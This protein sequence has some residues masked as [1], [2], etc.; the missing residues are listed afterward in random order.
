MSKR[1]VF[2]ILVGLAVLIAALLTNFG[3]NLPVFPP[4]NPVFTEVVPASRPP[5]LDW[6]QLERFAGQSMED[7]L[8]TLTAENEAAAEAE[9][10]KTPSEGAAPLPKESLLGAL[11]DAPLPFP[12]DAPPI[13][14]ARLREFVTTAQQGPVDDPTPLEKWEFNLALAALDVSASQLPETIRMDTAPAPESDTFPVRLVKR[15]LD[16]SGPFAVANFDDDPDLEIVSGGGT[17]VSKIADDSVVAASNAPPTTVAGRGL[18]PADFDGDGNVDLFVVRGAGLPNSLLRNDGA[19]QFEDVTIELGLLSFDDTTTAAWLDYDG[20][21]SLDLLVG[22]A[23]HPLELYHQSSGGVFQPIAWDL[24]LWVPRGVRGIEVADFSGN[25][26]PDF[27]LSI[28]GLGDRLCLSRPAESWENWRFP[29]RASEAGVAGGRDEASVAAAWD[30][31]ND[32]HADL[33]VGGSQEPGDAVRLYRNGGDETFVEVGADT[34]LAAVETASA[35]AVFDL[36][37]DGFEDLLIGT[38]QLAMNRLFWNRG[39]LGF[40][41]V[42]VVARASYLDRPLEFLA[43]DLDGDGASDLLSRNEQGRIRR[44]EAT[45]GGE[46]WL[47]IHLSGHAPGTRLRLTVRD[48]DW[49]LHSIARTVRLEDRITIGLGDA[50]L[51][52]QLDVLPPETDAPLKTLENLDPNEEL[53]IELP[54][55]PKQ[56]PVVPLSE[57]EAE[58][59]GN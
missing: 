32:G 16:V 39:G 47:L 15:E 17:A 44:L 31:D 48:D 1:T 54:K 37:N 3:R 10:A 41:E 35:F 23:D 24:Q 57:T 51:V 2:F 33:L 55:R 30:F 4:R 38:E 45:G 53:V 9:A 36:D 29:D 11:P 56:R 19:G 20:D 58:T 13:D 34:D 5:R 59:A 8:R 50:D 49:V 26:H 40:K 42:S 25:G 18:F 52:E 21:G 27:F 22:S 6:R 14:E 46:N 28:A 12:E 7:I 43:A